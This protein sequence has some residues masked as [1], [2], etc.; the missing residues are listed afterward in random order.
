MKIC[1][2]SEKQLSF[3]CTAYQ[4]MNTEKSQPFK[5]KRDRINHVPKM[6]MRESLQNMQVAC[7]NKFGGTQV[8]LLIWTGHFYSRGTWYMGKTIQGRSHSKAWAPKI[9]KNYFILC[10][11]IKKFK[12]LATK[13]EV[14]PPKCLS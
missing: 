6:S 4:T 10:I 12:Y 9:L 14:G 5:C 2:A 7:F 8:K 11:S 1:T 3:I 13:I